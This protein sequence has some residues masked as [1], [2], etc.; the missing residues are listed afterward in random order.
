MGGGEQQ[1][2]R[3][4][5]AAIALRN[6]ARPGRRRLGRKG[7]NRGLHVRGTPRGS[8]MVSHKWFTATCRCMSGVRPVWVIGDVV[9]LLQRQARLV[10]LTQGRCR[11]KKEEPSGGGKREGIG[12]Q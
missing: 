5:F 3:S 2:Q 1:Q 7:L 8:Q 6:T 4:I 11:E 9:L 12:H 10:R